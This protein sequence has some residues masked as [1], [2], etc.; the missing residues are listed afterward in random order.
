VVNGGEQCDDGVN[1]GTFYA[2]NPDCTIAPQCGDGIVQPEYGE[3]CE[4]TLADDPFCTAACRL[5]VRCN[6]RDCLY[7]PYCGDGVDQPEYGEECE[8]TTEN[9]PHCSFLCRFPECGNGILEWPEQCDD[10]AVL[11]IGKYGFCAPTC[12][13]AAHCGDG[14]VNGPEECDHGADNG[15]DG[16]CTSSCLTIIPWL[17]P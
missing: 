3:E 7:A 13:F 15:I 1:D 16:R 11:N 12:I 6:E 5:P 4:P 9:D 2:C 8:P 14:I 17:P 10:G